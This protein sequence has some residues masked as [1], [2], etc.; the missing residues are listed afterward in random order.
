MPPEFPRFRPATDVT[1]SVPLFLDTNAI[2]AHEYA[3]ASRH[4]EVRP[5][6]RA[7][8]ANDLPYYPLV[9]NQYVL[10]EVVSLL[11][12]HATTRVAHRALT[13]VLD[14]DTVRVLDVEPSL[15]DRAIEQF[16]AYEDQSISLTDHVIA[17]QADD[18]GIEHVFSY[19]GGFR[20]LEFSTLPRAG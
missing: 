6:M 17:V 18:H 10:D 8:G 12:S 14:T 1:G 16:Q 2:V 3:K 13:R 7:I 15:V 19:D 9:T 20:T 5:V 11:L 4:D